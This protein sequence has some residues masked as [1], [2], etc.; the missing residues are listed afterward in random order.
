MKKILLVFLM[1]VSAVVLFATTSF[2]EGTGNLVI[3][4]QAWDEEYDYSTL[5]SWAW[6]DNIAGK[7]NDGVDDFGAYW[8]YN[9]VAVGTTVG[10][11]AVDW[12][13]EGGPDW[14]AK[15]T[16]DVGISSDAI[17]ENETVHVYIFEGAASEK[18]GD[19]FLTFP[20]FVSSPS[21]YNMLLVYF[22]PSDSYEENLGVH[23]WNGWVN[24]AEAYGTDFGVWATPAK[25]FSTAGKT[26]DGRTVKAAMLHSTAPDAGLLVYAGD[27]ATKKTGDVLLGSALPE[28][29]V[30]G[31]VGVAYVVSK[32][33]EYTAGDNV[34]YNDNVAFATEAFAFGLKAFDPEKMEGTYAVDPH[35]VIV[36]TSAQLDNPYY[37]ATTEAEQD[38]AV[39]T[40]KSWFTV[41]E[42]T[43]EDTYGD[44]LAVERVDFAKTNKTLDSFV[45]ILSDALDNTKDYEIFFDLGNLEPLAEAKDVTITLNVTVPEDNAEAVIT[46][47]SSANS[48]TP[49]A[50][51]YA[52]TQVGTT[53][54]WELTF[55]VSVIEPYTTVEYKWTNG[56]WDVVEKISGNRVIVVPNN[57]DSL[58]FDDVI[59]WSGDEYDPTVRGEATGP[60]MKASLPIEMDKEAPVLSFISPT[61]ITGLPANERIIEVAW[62]EAF[63]Q[64]LFPRVRVTDDRD[65]DLT[66]FV[67]VPSGQYSTLDTR[68]EGDYTIMLMVEDRWGNVTS[69]TFIFR[70]VVEE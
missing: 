69:E 7:R 10:F 45:V 20:S 24:D 40:I 12:P 25:V 37:A 39:E 41:K 48:W 52:A 67:Y 17:V 1:A 54:V 2:A 26:S 5:G 30:V 31:D 28:T 34:Y 32:G 66:P 33:N 15:L 43:G 3:H 46:I 61:A 36:K 63:N 59:A 58:E 49:G 29:P 27:D 6:G 51:G 38:A 21:H 14:N 13:T 64:N 44:A 9:D 8:N 60:N 68:T 16:G 18:D 50:D 22:D 23:A 42:I 65:G 55:T 53:N 35:T 56:T 62:G 4:F 57:V 11:I 19:T 70:V 47:G